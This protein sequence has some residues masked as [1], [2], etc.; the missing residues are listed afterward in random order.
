MSLIVICIYMCK[1]LEIV[2]KD[3]RF[4]S[5]Y[6]KVGILGFINQKTEQY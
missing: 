2:R 5:Q 6:E 4:R 3:L 1:L